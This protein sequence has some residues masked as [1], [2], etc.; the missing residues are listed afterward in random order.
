M[1]TLVRVFLGLALLASGRN[2]A[3]NPVPS[4]AY[5]NCWIDYWDTYDLWCDVWATAADGSGHR[6]QDNGTEPAWSPDGSKIAFGRFNPAGGIAVLDVVNGTLTELTTGIGR[7]PAWSPDGAR[8]AFRDS[9][10][11]G[12]IRVANADGSGVV[13]LTTSA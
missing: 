7:G 13:Q 4:I 10:G 3:A 11:P 9:A 5:Q 6:L 1:K 12:D 2:A 8:I